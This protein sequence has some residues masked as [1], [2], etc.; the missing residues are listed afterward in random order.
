[1]C[2]LFVSVPT[3]MKAHKKAK[4]FHHPRH[5]TVSYKMRDFGLQQWNVQ[6]HNIFLPFRCIEWRNNDYN[7]KFG[8]NSKI[9]RTCA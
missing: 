6:A 4:K 3:C 7:R 1:M 8:H 9:T 2:T 5:S